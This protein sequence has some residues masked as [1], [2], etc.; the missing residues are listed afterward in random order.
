M[1]S[2]ALKKSMLDQPPAGVLK[3]GF[4]LPVYLYRVGLG[5]ILGDRFLMLT[6]TGRK[7]GLS[8]QTVIEVVGHDRQQG[9]YYGVSGW[10][11]KSDWYRNVQTNPNVKIQVGRRRFAA[12]A[13]SVPAD[14]AIGIMEAYTR[15]H[16]I[17]FRELT[18]LFLGEQLQP[19][20]QAAQ[21][22][23][24]KMPMVAFREIR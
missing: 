12:R 23:T 2:H 3:A 11:K 19:G 24:D 1:G 22:L 9:T 21:R 5:W 14:E 13:E 20:S 16:P 10:G 17:A 18:G 4:R 8:H 7:S 15:E 6:H